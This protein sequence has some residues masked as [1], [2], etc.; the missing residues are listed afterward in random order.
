M[1]VICRLSGIFF[2]LVSFGFL[3][4]VTSRYM[5]IPSGEHTIH[6]FG[7]HHSPHQ[8]DAKQLEILKNKLQERKNKLWVG[9]EVMSLCDTRIFPEKITGKLHTFTFPSHITIENIEVR[10]RALLLQ[11]L[12]EKRCNLTKEST[13][14]SGD[15]EISIPKVTV[16]DVWEELSTQ[17]EETKST[18]EKLQNA[19]E[20]YNDSKTKLEELMQNYSGN[21][22]LHVVSMALDP[23]ERNTIKNKVQQIAVTIFDF[24]TLKKI[25]TNV[26]SQDVA[27]FAGD[28]HIQNI[29]DFLVQSAKLTKNYGDPSSTVPVKDEVFDCL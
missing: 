16:H 23:E 2:L 28:T 21:G 1:N 10:K 7:V 8:A 24:L 15:E 12:F 13:F 25:L 5:Q 3:N 22:S 29:K 9:L 11:H 18:V 17:L 14:I 19:K 27:I 20:L 26:Q 4:A 6:L